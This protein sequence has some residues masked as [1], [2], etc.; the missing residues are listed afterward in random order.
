MISYKVWVVGKVHGVGFRFY[1]MQMAYKYGVFGFVK[2]LS[3]GKVYMELEG[4][5]EKID[6]FLDWCR[7]GP[8]GAKVNEILLENNSL[9]N[10]TAFN[11]Q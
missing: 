4:E 2:N 7:I 8:M 6:L 3:D 10:F 5:L 1:S 11:I 9:K